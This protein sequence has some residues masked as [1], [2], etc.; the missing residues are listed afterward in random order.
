[1]LRTSHCFRFR[2]TDSR[3]VDSIV[4]DLFRADH[5]GPCATG[6]AP[7][8][9][10]LEVPCVRSLLV[11][12]SSLYAARQSATIGLDQSSSSGGNYL[13]EFSRVNSED[14]LADSWRVL[15]WRVFA[16]N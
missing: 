13:G 15:Y 7:C 8:T 10:Y 11:T 14:V 4:M 3:K 9:P 1:M 6:G 12:T 5:S 16:S 2:E